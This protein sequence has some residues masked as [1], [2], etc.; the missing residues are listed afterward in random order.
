MQS[1]LDKTAERLIEAVSSSWPT[2]AMKELQLE[3]TMGFDSSSGHS[4][5]HQKFSDNTI[6]SQS[7]HQ[8]LFVSSMLIIRIKSK[9]D[10]NYS[11]VNPTPQSYRFCRPLRIAFEK[12][13]EVSIEKEYNRLNNQMCNITSYKFNSQ[14]GK[15][16]NVSYD[17]YTTLFDGKC[18]NHLTDN[19]ATTRCP[20]CH[21][22]M[23][24][25]GKKNEI[26]TPKQG[27][28]KFGLSPLHAEIKCL[29]Q[30]LHTAYRKNIGR[31]KITAEYKGLS[32]MIPYYKV[33][34]KRTYH[35]LIPP[36]PP[37]HPLIHYPSR[38]IPSK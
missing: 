15:P 25:F 36:N 3:A 26:F 28:L 4:N 34:V 6:D 10:E 30:L 2:S 1:L 7:S 27:S 12:E 33:I 22:T 9:I 38:T 13:D 8:T 32:S 35:L 16:V 21:K 11:W 37:I 24:Q 29:E 5:P 19:P 18:V 23:T 14:S 20:I 31:W 17:L